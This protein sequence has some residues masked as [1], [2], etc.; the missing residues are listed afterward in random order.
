MRDETTKERDELA[1][2]LGITPA[3]ATQELQRRK[4]AA[5]TARKT[6]H[7]DSPKSESDAT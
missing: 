6:V 2:K 7:I 4:T 1:K 5:E 3:A